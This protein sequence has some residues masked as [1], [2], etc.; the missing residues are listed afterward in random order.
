MALLFPGIYGSGERF[1][2]VRPGMVF[3]RVL[4]TLWDGKARRELIICMDVRPG[5]VLCVYRV[6]LTLRV[7]G[8]HWVVRP[9]ACHYRVLDFATLDVLGCVT[10]VTCL[11]CA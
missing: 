8:G 10:L 6:L 5:R 3:S 2:R 1:S 11:A 9:L 7:F 4:I